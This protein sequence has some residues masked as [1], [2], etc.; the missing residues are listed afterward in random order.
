MKG[1]ETNDMNSPTDSSNDNDDDG[2][3]EPDS[4]TKGRPGPKS[5]RNRDDDPFG[6]DELAERAV[7]VVLSL[8]QR[9]RK[10]AQG[11]LLFSSVACIGGYLLGVFALKGGL[12][13]F[14]VIA[15]ALLAL[16][17]IGSV[18]TALWRLRAVRNGSDALVSEVRSLVGDDRK[19]ERTVIE[20]ID[21][22]KSSENDGIV[23]LTRQFSSLR[24]AVRGHSS[25]F[26]Q[27]SLALTSITTFPGLMAL[28]TVIGAGFA[29][30]SL[31]FLLILIF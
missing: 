7:E 30:A 17:A 12:R 23:V 15:G 2:V 13:T 10:L 11:V 6:L 14:W 3:I 25:N 29:A 4:V 9:A 8:L 26:V 1:D 19:S 31:I 20:T 16:W 18:V 27:L 24:D 28:A 5:V 21:S 22:S